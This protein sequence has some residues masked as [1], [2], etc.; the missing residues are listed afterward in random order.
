M[1]S[2]LNAGVVRCVPLSSR[3][4]RRLLTVP[5]VESP[6]SPPRG[7]PPKSNQHT[8]LACRTAATPI[9][10]KEG[11][12]SPQNGMISTRS[13]CVLPPTAGVRAACAT[14]ATY[15]RAVSAAKAAHSALE[16]VQ[17]ISIIIYCTHIKAVLDCCSGSVQTRA[18]SLPAH[19]SLR[20]RKACLLGGGLNEQAKLGCD[21]EVVNHG[22]LSF[23]K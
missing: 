21:H 5:V 12:Q 11:E 16:A 22:F 19:D 17:R 14:A 3:H 23:S 1:L 2:T 18:A 6:P 20:L 15:S 7:L 8:H 4:H 13:G 10:S 9:R